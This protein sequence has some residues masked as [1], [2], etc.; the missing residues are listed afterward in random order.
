MTQEIP[1]RPNNTITTGIYPNH[2]VT[3]TSTYS[4]IGF[5]EALFGG[6]PNF[7]GVAPEGGCHPL[8]EVNATETIA[9]AGYPE[10]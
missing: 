9:Y 4:S 8:Q 6:I 2:P 5:V 1:H 10:P 3:T 7:G